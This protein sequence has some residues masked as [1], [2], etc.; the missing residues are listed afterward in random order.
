MAREEGV[1]HLYAVAGGGLPQRVDHHARASA[2]HVGE[3]R[4]DGDAGGLAVDGHGDV[5]RRRAAREAASPRPVA[6]GDAQEGLLGTRGKG[7]GIDLDLEGQGLA[8]VGPADGAP[9]QL[10]GGQGRLALRVREHDAH[11]AH[12]TARIGHADE[13]P[14]ALAAEQEALGRGDLRLAALEAVPRHHGRTGDQQR[15][16]GQEQATSAHG[17]PRPAS[18]T[19]GPRRRRRRGGRLD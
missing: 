12:A 9:R 5:E 4:G 17:S 8:V 18:L 11:A 10:A 14:S 19:E 3:P 6:G 1:A 15:E 7:A 16:D 2:A 13:D